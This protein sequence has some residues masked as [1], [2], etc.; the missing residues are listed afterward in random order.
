MYKVTITQNSF[1]ELELEYECQNEVNDL[2]EKVFAGDT[3]GD[4]KIT[5]EIT[6][7]ENK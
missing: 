6:E 3:K 4:I 2:V 5:I 7:G 1:R